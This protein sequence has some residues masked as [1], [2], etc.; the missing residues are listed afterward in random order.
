MWSSDE[1]A[2]F[3]FPDDADRLNGAMIQAPLFAQPRRSERS[4]MWLPTF[5]SRDRPSSISLKNAQSLSV[6]VIRIAEPRADRLL[7]RVAPGCSKPK[8][9]R[10]SEAEQ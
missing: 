9:R 6:S 3:R 4:G 2:C 5:R 10:L 1:R 7:S 8:T